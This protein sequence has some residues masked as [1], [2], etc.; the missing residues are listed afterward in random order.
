MYHYI[1]LFVVKRPQVM[2]LVNEA[3]KIVIGNTG[4]QEDFVHYK[5]LNYT[6]MISM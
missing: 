4:I 2:S 6:N 3:W 1:Y 5:K